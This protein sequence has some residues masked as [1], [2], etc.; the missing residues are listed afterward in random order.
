MRLINHLACA[1]ALSLVC[2]GY[3]SIALADTADLVITQGRILTMDSDRTRASAIAVKGNTI[4]FVGDDAAAA[5]FIGDGTQVIDAGGQII[6][7]GL[8]DV[9]IHP[10]FAIDPVYNG[11]KFECN[12]EGASVDLDETVAKLQTCLNEATLNDD[13]WLVGK[14]FNPPSLLSVT[15][16]YPSVIAALDAVS[17]ITPILLEGSD[18]HAFGANTAALA[19]AH[20]PDTGVN[21]AVT[22]ASLKADYE[23]FAEYFNTD[24]T[25]NPDGTAKDFAGYIIGAPVAGLDNYK[26]VL[27]DLVKLMA[28]NGVTSAQDA[29][30]FDEI[31]DVY[32]YMEEQGLLKFRLRLNTHIDSN[33]L[34]GRT[35]DLDLDAAMDKAK[36]MRARFDGSDY[37]KAD[38]VKLF[39]DG[40]V[41]Y[42]TQT[43]AMLNPYLEPIV[44]EAMNLSDYVDQD[45]VDCRDA[46]DHMESYDVPAAAAAFRAEHG[47]DAT[48]CEK[49]YGLL[50][51]TPSEL[52]RAVTAFDAEGFTVHMH[53]IGDGAVKTG[54]DAIEAARTANGISGL[55]HNLAHI[56]FVADEEIERIGKMGVVV[57]PTMAWAVPFWEYDTTVN[58]FINTVDSLLEMDKLYRQDGLWA[59]RVYPFRSIRDAGGI[60]AA[61]SD[62]PVDV[63]TPQPFV[64]MAAGLIRADLLPVDPLSDDPNQETVVVA[65]NAEEVL[66]LD[67]VLAAYTINGAFA[68][69]Q[70]DLTGSLEVGKRADLIM[71]N[72]DIEALS[73]NIETIWGIAETEVL[74]TVFDGKVVHDAR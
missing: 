41:E 42:P 7:P 12:F 36:A 25:G 35:R 56:Q 57:T 15:E 54:L 17:T 70:Q 32:A 2:G 8:H 38:G 48:Q 1:T 69:G 33:V 66:N 49:R 24:N 51:F 62:A 45:G 74:M 4:V 13:G 5:E 21:T 29:W 3:A 72:T 58:P 50:E 28:S 53:A 64:N 27:D 67:D 65:I 6:L 61:G 23:A 26:P 47:H 14:Y 43:A 9:H 16:T 22:G 60:I 44:D 39:V 52:S 11:E 40:V 63:P 31:A 59:D 68:M 55:P 20:H 10:L 73:Q 30:V 46:R 19:R 71:I 34:G 37:I 18:G